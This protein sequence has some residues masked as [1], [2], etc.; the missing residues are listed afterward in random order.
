LLRSLHEKSPEERLLRNLHE[1]NQA[2]GRLLRNLH[3][4]SQAERKL[5]R[6]LHEEKREDDKHFFLFFF[7]ILI[8]GNFNLLNS[9][10]TQSLQGKL[11]I[12]PDI[13]ELHG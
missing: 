13:L 8:F 7:L 4:E 3:E 2:E 1:E 11:Y 5:L 12:F 10:Y 9:C 6:S